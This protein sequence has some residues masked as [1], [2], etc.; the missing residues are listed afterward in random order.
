M[1]VIKWC[2][3][4][5]CACSG[6]KV[7]FQK[8]CIHFS[9][10]V[11]PE[12]IRRVFELA[13]IPPSHDLGKY[14]GAPSIQGRSSHLLFQPLI[15][16]IASR[17]LGWKTATLSF[18]RR[19]TLA[20]SVLT[21]IP[22]YTMQSCLLPV[23]CNKIDKLIRDFIWGHSEMRRGAHLLNWGIVTRGKDRGGPD[24]R[25]TRSMNLALLAKLGWRLCLKKDTL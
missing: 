19:V 10:G 15:D 18:A 2:L 12:V 16:R 3:D 8:S 22:I 6:Q 9:W 17:L 1:D 11:N 20:S 23:V 5:L 14:L 4:S 13:G 25:I 21:V 24:I 7:S